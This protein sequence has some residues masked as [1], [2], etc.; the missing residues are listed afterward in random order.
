[1]TSRRKTT[2]STETIRR[3]PPSGNLFH[4]R[5]KKLTLRDETRVTIQSITPEDEPRMIAFHQTL[6]DQSVH[7]R[8]FGMLSL[9]F[10]TGH[11]RLARL[12]STDLARE[13][14]LVAEEKK[15]TENTKS[16]E[17]VG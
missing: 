15:V 7:S 12:C 8:Y 11:E 1:M 13:I 14:A 2:P 10:R 6:S 9:E 17:S 4:F 3:R 5:P 16:L